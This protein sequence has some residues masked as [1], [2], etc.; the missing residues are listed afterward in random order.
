MSFD[1][2]GTTILNSQI[3]QGTASVF[4]AYTMLLRITRTGD[5]TQ[6][7]TA[8]FLEGGGFNAAAGHGGW[9]SMHRE[10]FM[11]EET[12]ATESSDL[13]LDFNVQHSANASGENFTVESVIAR[14][15]PA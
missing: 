3:S 4:H 11:Y 13:A 6:F 1:L 9:S 15:I 5:D 2:G 8:R 7:V 10:G 14:I 12:S